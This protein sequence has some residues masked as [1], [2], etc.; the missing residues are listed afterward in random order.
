MKNKGK[1]A[2]IPHA[3]CTGNAA[4]PCRKIVP[5]GTILLKRRI[6]QRKLS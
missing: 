1:R 3:F 4:Q 2:A 5:R 6:T